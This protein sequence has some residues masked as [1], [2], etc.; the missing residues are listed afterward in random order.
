MIKSLMYM[1]LGGIVALGLV[2]GG[3]AAFAQ[4]T[5]EGTA[6]PDTSGDSIQQD[7]VPG[8]SMP[9]FSLR[10]NGRFGGSHGPGNR[11]GLAVDN[12]ALLA[13][14]LGITT[15]ELQTAKQTAHAAI[16]AQ[17]VA[18][19]LLTQDQADA[20]LNGEF[21]RHDGFGFGGRGYG[22]GSADH[23]TY[24]AEALGI[25]VEALNA[26]QEAARAAARQQALDEGLITQ[27]QLD[28]ITAAQTLKDA[29]DQDAIMAEILGVT[30]EEFQAAR[31]ART[32]QD[33][34]DAAGLTQAELITAVQA[35]HQA[36]LQ[37]AIADGLITQEQADAL[38]SGRGFGLDGLGGGRGNGGHGGMR[39][40][41]AGDCNPGSSTTP[42]TSAPANTA[43]SSNA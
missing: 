29:T 27:E 3:Y 31:E 40:F 17:A 32:V 25:S 26:A 18:D 28:L 20:M 11:S 35:A 34:V 6:A 8:L 23:A 16:I 33:L 38:S 7:T 10:G 22:L 13:E 43:S 39:G 21:G 9:G 24:L 41:G 15:D 12:D 19:G 4:T 2:F 42:D 30:V 5:D 14:A 37:Q 36:A 1:F